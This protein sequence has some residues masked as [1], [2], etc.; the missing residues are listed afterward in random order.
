VGLCGRKG[1]EGGVFGGGAKGGGTRG[2]ERIEA[3]WEE[4]RC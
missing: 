1:D 4:R 2:G 3:E